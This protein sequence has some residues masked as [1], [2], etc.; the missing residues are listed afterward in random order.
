MSSRLSFVVP[1]LDEATGIAA[2]LSHLHHLYPHCET[3]VVDGGSSDGTLQ[4]A[5][6][7]C[8]LALLGEAGRASQMNLGAQAATGD[9]LLFLHADSYPSAGAEALLGALDSE[10]SWGFCR[11]QLSG[12]RKVFRLI[13]WA[14]NRRSQ[15]TGVATGDQMLF[16]RREAWGAWGGFA[17]IPLMEDVELC[18]RWRSHAPPRVVQAPVLTSSRRWEQRGVLRTIGQMWR[19]RLAFALGASPQRLWQSYYGS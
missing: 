4:A 16:C 10:L 13:E 2:L 9:V 11:V 18:K 7:H 6:P 3:V 12:K 5:L 1:V 8:T 14:M 15:C 19:L 17:P